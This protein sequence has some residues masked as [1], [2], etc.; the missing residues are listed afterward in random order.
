[1]KADTDRKIVDV[2]KG[3]LSELRVR[4]RFEKVAPH[5]SVGINT[6]TIVGRAGGSDLRGT[7]TIEVLP[8]SADLRVTPRTLQRR[9]CGEDV[10]AR[11]EFSE[12]VNAS[13]VSASSIRMNGTVPAKVVKKK[14]REL[15]KVRP[16]RRH[17]GAAEGHW[18]GG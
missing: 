16:R 6:A 2:D 13:K 8:L 1:V 15:S 11:I 14:G 9:S 18:S 3:G 7:G 12:G 4:F 10:E 17:R 5:L